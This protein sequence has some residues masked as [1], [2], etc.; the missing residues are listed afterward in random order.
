MHRLGD[1]FIQQYGKYFFDLLKELDQKI[2]CVEKQLE[3]E[4]LHKK[5]ENTNE[6]HDSSESVQASSE[7]Q[8]KIR[9]PVDK[10]EVKC[11]KPMQN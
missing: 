11:L 3:Q 2:K 1:R 6:T 9:A 7:K 4:I 5:I 8:I 10:S